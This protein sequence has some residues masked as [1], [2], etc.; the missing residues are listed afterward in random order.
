[1]SSPTNGRRALSLIV[2]AFLA[3]AL[4]F[5]ILS[6]TGVLSFSNTAVSG[7]TGSEKIPFLTD[8]RVVNRFDKLGLEVNARK[9]GSR[10]IATHFDLESY[11]FSFPSGAAAT[12]KIKADHTTTA[13]HD[14]FYSPMVIATRQ[15]ILEILIANGIAQDEGGWYSFD[16]AKYLELLEEGTRWSQLKESSAFDVNKQVL[17]TS[18]D[19]RKSNSAAM[20]LAML[21]YL[22][23]GQSVVR[24]PAQAKAAVAQIAPAFLLQGFS[25]SSSS[26]PFNN[27]LVRGMG[28]VPMVMAY[29]AQFIA[30]AI[31]ENSAIT[32]DMVMMYPQPTVF[33]QHTVVAHSEAGKTFAEQL[34]TDPELKS[35]AAA[36]GFRG[37]NDQELMNLVNAAGQQVPASINYVVDPPAYEFL[38]A[39]INELEAAYR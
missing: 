25:E 10:E 28:S 39:M 26:A 16:L 19:I 18:T 31:N 29:E 15:P 32:S 7:L 24:T 3:L 5:A 12:A 11:D 20:Y 8:E 35:L 23:N 30:E 17:I 2:A 34:A 13:S 14:V 21:S 27:Y 38:E 9:A 1:M 22:A 4:L 37:A 6:Q 36:F 33:S